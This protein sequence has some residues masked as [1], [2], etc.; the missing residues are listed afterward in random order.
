MTEPDSFGQE[1]LT[2]FPACH[3][4]PGGEV[5]VPHA[6]AVAAVDLAQELGLQLLG[7]EGFLVGETG[8]YPSMSRITDYSTP[9]FVGNPYDDAKAL[10]TG[11]WAEI[12]DDLHGDAEGKYL[13]DLV[14]AS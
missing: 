2:R 12:P 8:V 14:V 7:M 5:W 13:I 1:L 10:L 9:R 11:D 3:V 4:T 6:D